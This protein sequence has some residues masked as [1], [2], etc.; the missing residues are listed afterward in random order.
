VYRAIG[1]VTGG[2]IRCFR[3]LTWIRHLGRP[4]PT[5]ILSPPSHLPILKVATYRGF[6]VLA[7]EPNREIVLGTVLIAPR[8]APRPRTAAE[9]CA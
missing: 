8:D 6:I 1:D 5:G 4:H 3:T 7:D 2:E 9:F